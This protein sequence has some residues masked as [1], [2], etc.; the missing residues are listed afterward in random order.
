MNVS[1]DRLAKLIR[2]AAASCR[3]ICS[4]SLSRRSFEEASGEFCSLQSALQIFWRVGPEFDDP[5][6][7]VGALKA[8]KQVCERGL[9]EVDARRAEINLTAARLVAYFQCR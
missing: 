2:R 8:A 5:A 1:L 3:K 6:P 7:V 9:K 4:L